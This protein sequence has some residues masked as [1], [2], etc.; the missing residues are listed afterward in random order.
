MYVFSK[1]KS[2]PVLITAACSSRLLVLAV[3]YVIVC[4]LSEV[5]AYLWTVVIICWFL[6]I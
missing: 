5:S 4:L 2:C 6:F 1:T 3:V